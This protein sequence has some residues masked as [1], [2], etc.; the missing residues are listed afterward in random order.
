MEAQLFNVI[1]TVELKLDTKAHAIQHF[2]S[3]RS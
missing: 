1:L 2:Y 3:R